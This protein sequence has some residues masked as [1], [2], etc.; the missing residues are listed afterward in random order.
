MK[1]L[2]FVLLCCCFAITFSL[3]TRRSN[4]VRAYRSLE[5]PEDPI[6]R[7]TMVWL[8]KRRTQIA[9]VIQKNPTIA[10]ESKD[11]LLEALQKHPTADFE[12][13][14]CVVSDVFIFLF[15]FEGEM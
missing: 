5:G 4:N 14:G 8:S 2:I 3:P 13:N 1:H 12:C 6:N 11:K 15:L 10:Q 7:K 9:G